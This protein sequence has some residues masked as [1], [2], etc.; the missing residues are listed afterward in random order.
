MFASTYDSQAGVGPA[1]AG[2]GADAESKGR[3]FNWASPG[4]MFDV[5]GL[6]DADSLRR[7]NRIRALTAVMDSIFTIPG[8]KFRVGLDPIIG[9]IPILGD[10]ISAL[11]SLYIVY[12]ARRLGASRRII[13]LMLANVALDFALGLTPVAGDAFDAVFKANIRNL[14]LLGLVPGWRRIV[15]AARRVV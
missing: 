3:G 8:T 10:V 7:I 14:A 15:P 12:Q 1:P 5:A 4:V 6:R 9:M 13:M 2:S 11:V